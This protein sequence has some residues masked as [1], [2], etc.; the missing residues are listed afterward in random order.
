MRAATI[1]IAVWSTALLPSPCLC[2]LFEADCLGCDAP[3][4]GCDSDCKV[5]PCCG[6]LVVVDGSQ[7]QA[8]ASTAM[9]SVV[10][11]SPQNATLPSFADYLDQS[12]PPRHLPFHRSDIPLLI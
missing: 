12:P 2:E 10:Q 3:E 5:S 9:G 6:P 8:V 4:S 7:T 11:P 1:L